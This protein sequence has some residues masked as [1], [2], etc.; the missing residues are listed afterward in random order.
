MDWRSMRRQ[1]FHDVGQVGGMHAFEFLVRDA[2]LHAAQRVRLDQVDEFPGDDARWQPG[3][4]PAHQTRRGNA[5]Q[6][7]AGGARQAHV[8]LRDAQFDRAVDALLGEINVVHADNFSAA[9]IDDL[10]VEQVLAHGQ[11]GFIGLVMFEVLLFHV[12]ADDARGDEGDVIVTHDQ[13]KKFSPAKEDPRHT[14][15][16]VGGLDEQFGDLADEMAV[17]VVGFSAQEIGCV[18][19]FASFPKPSAVSALGLRLGL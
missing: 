15:R 9:G 19:H 14:V 13:G 2:E 4:Q 3:R 12:Q 5:V 17:A 16:L 10:L 7:A 8:H 1:L 6:Q 11:P 18:Q